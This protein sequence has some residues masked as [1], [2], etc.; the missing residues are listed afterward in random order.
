MSFSLLFSF[1]KQILSFH[2]PYL[3]RR[4]QQ[5]IYHHQSLGF[6][7]DV[8]LSPCKA[9]L[10]GASSDNCLFI[11]KWDAL[12]VGQSQPVG[13]AFQQERQNSVTPSSIFSSEHDHSDSQSDGEGHSDEDFVWNEVFGVQ[14]LP[15]TFSSIQNVIFQPPRSYRPLRTEDVSSGFSDQDFFDFSDEQLSPG[16]I[17]QP[18]VGPRPQRAGEGSDRIS[19]SDSLDDDIFEQRF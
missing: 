2:S 16:A 15:S 8:A 17:T 9:Y 1:G 4:H 11:W 19:D 5:I 12:D 3:A 13:K 14:T 10:V 7:L 18:L 6:I